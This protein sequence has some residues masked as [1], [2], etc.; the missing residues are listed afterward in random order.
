[1]EGELNMSADFTPT[2][3][4]YKSVR[5]F[6]A[7]CQKVLPTIYDDSLSYY[8]L[9][10]RLLMY[11]KDTISNIDG[12]YD[13]I[14]ELNETY[15]KLEEYVNSYFDSLDV[16]SEV[17]SE[18]E[19]TL[20][21]MASSGELATM[22]YQFFNFRLNIKF[23]VDNLNDSTFS[24]AFS[25]TLAITPYLYIP[26][27]TYNFDVI[28][29]I[30]VDS[31]VDIILH[32]NA[33]LS[34]TSY[35]EPMFIFN[36]SSVRIQGGQIRAGAS[37]LSYDML[38]NPDSRG[39]N[40]GALIFRYSKN[41]EI[42]SIVS[43][44]CKLPAVIVLLNTSNVTIK[45][46]DFNYSLLNGVHILEHCVQ[47]VIENNNFNVI[48]IPNNPDGIYYCYAVSTGLQRLSDTGIVPPDIL[49]YR[50]NTV[51]NSDD[52]GLDTHG[53]TNVLIE[54]NTITDCNTCI[55]AYNDSN[56][57]TR[58]EGWIMENL[59]IRNNICISD[60]VFQGSDQHPYILVSSSNK[61]ARDCK[62]LV[63][64]NNVF[65]S[66]NGR[67]VY[68]NALLPLGRWA[69]VQITRNIFDGQGELE[70]GIYVNRA[71]RVIIENNM[72][73]NLKRYSVLSGASSRSECRMNAYS[74]S[75]SVSQAS[76]SFNY[77]KE[78]SGLFGL[79]KNMNAIDIDY[80]DA[81]YYMNTTYGICNNGMVNNPISCIYND[82]VLSSENEL[83]LYEGLRLDIGSASVIVSEIL[84]D[85]S[86]RVK[87]ISGTI[88]NGTISYTIHEA[89][90]TTC[91]DR[92]GAYSGDLNNAPLGFSLISQ[93]VENDPFEYSNFKTPYIV[94]TFWARGYGDM[95]GQVAIQSGFLYTRYQYSSGWTEWKRIAFQESQNSD[96]QPAE[97]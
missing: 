19:Q 59:I 89:R 36:N 62:N 90:L 97:P 11:I 44:W 32:P 66:P 27:G 65:S 6:M 72:F 22:L 94:Y 12:F 68:G 50:N 51:K 17:R 85:Y 63:I 47:T 18:V 60:Y 75:G 43:N 64:D 79:C 69:N 56:R 82:E 88:E 23:A 3:K 77:I 24:E 52:S 28:G 92:Q 2:L 71:N 40:G 74:N 33:I 38:Y 80:T 42:D 8:E 95:K 21:N 93:E 96:P 84:S 46:C 34:I 76:G 87:I 54:G 55:T 45:N 14:N 67:S 49:I 30:V 73:K 58:P 57:V 26:E 61:N 39:L 4:P 48:N 10:S 16:P 20:D 13:D 7:W 29:T 9:L 91:T 25:K 1:M 81:H 53:A 41:V 78:D 31:N 15:R 5:P 37:K 83:N 35:T 70:I 86:A